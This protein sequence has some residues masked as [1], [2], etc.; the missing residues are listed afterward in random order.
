MNDNQLYHLPTKPGGNGKIIA[1]LF[2]GLVIF[3]LTSWLT[4]QYLAYSFNYHKNLSGM[5]YTVGSHKIY[6]PLTWLIWHKQLK[7][8]TEAVN[9]HFIIA[10]II[11]SIG[12]F[13][14]LVLALSLAKKKSKKQSLNYDFH[15]SA[16]WATREEIEKT[17]LLG[18]K[19]NIY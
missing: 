6:N 4:T 7:G 5:L 8:L 19:P 16:R 1:I 3:L 10:Y 12:S 14:S 13:I 9:Y 17:G 2:L 11:M 18:I 15:G